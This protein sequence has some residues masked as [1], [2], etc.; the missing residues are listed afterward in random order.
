[1]RSHDLKVSKVKAVV[2]RAGLLTMFST[3]T[4]RTPSGP[5]DVDLLKDLRSLGKPPTFGGT[6]A[7]YQ[8]FRFCSN[9]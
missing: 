2:N 7:E 9:C 8:D 1:M 5:L 6:D 3:Q 4:A